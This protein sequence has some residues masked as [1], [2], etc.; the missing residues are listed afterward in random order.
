LILKIQFEVKSFFPLIRVCGELATVWQGLC[1]SGRR[2]DPNLTLQKAIMT[3][4][5]RKRKTETERLRVD[6]KKRESTAPL[7]PVLLGEEEA[8]RK[9]CL[10]HIHTMT[11]ESFLPPEFCHIL[12]SSRLN[13]KWIKYR[14]FLSL[15]NT[16]PHNV[17]V[18]ICFS[19]C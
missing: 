19:K 11:S 6:Q 18:E 9:L 2:T 17:I 8:G 1:V 3:P 13:L 14:L 10:P 7:Y 15:A 5:R 4:S 16:I 12:L